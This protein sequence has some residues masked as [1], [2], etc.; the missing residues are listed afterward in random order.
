MIPFMVPV[1]SLRYSSFSYFALIGFALQRRKAQ[2]LD[3]GYL[4]DSRR[5][6]SMQR[7]AT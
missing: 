4:N 2:D 7:W 3:I 1:V 6:L 5:V